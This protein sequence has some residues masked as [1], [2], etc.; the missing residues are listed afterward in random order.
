MEFF[1]CPNRMIKEQ[2]NGVGKTDTAQAKV[3]KNTL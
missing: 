1:A 3:F 2:E